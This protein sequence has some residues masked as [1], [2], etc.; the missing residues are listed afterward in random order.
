M[1]DAGI[2][3]LL[4]TAQVAELLNVAPHTLAVWRSEGNFDIP[5]VKIGRAV[6]YRLVDVELYLE[7]QT[8][9]GWTQ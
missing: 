6:R 2:P 7:R 5:F 4:T 8:Q 3:R 1:N 9:R